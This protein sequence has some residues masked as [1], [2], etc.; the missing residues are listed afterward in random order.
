L[1]PRIVDGEELDQRRLDFM[2]IILNW[3]RIA[4]SETGVAPFP[5]GLFNPR[6]MEY[7]ATTS[8]QARDDKAPWCSSFINWCFMQVGIA[9]TGPALARSWL[10]WGQRVATPRW[11]C[12]AILYRDDPASWKGHVGF[13]LRADTGICVLAKR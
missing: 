4:E 1:R 5:P 7:H 9:G 6:I 11:G 2:E 12:V 8:F 3:M 10:E 13:F